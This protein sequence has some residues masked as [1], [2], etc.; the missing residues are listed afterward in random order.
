MKRPPIR[1]ARL[2]PLLLL[3]TSCSPFAPRGRV[4]VPGEGMPESFSM[5]SAEPPAADAPWWRS[6][7]FEELDELERRALRGN[8]T[9]REAW[10]RLKQ[11]EAQARKAGAPIYPQIDAVANASWTRYQEPPLPGPGADSAVEDYMLGLAGAYELDLWGRI[12]SGHRAV[13]LQA[14]ASREDLDTALM[15]VSARV[16]ELWLRV[17]GSR[18]EID[19]MKAQVETNRQILELVEM[20]FRKSAGS[21]LDVYRQR[22]AVERT[23]S[24]I[25]QI[26]AAERTFRNELAVMLGLPPESDLAI[27]TAELPDPG[28]LPPTGLPAD[29]LARRPDVRAAFARLESADWETAAA[30]ADRLPAIR[31]TGRGGYGTQEFE[32]IFDNWFLNLAGAVTGPIVDGGRRRAEVDRTLAQVD[33]R[34]ASYRKTVLTALREVED[35]LV[36]ENRQAEYVRRLEKQ[37]E[38][39]K[40]ALEEARRQYLKGLLDYLSVLAELQ[41]VQN[42]QRQILRARVERLVYRVAL[43]R[44]LGGTWMGVW[45]PRDGDAASSGPGTSRAVPEGKAPAEEDAER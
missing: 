12:R 17:I 26:E 23:A 42:L 7:G 30:R 18:M 25:P 32:S 21:A 34:L 31:L 22:E 8:L 35:A 39:A 43:Y 38:A 4:L 37:M 33:E 3:A 29:L 9:L 15:T 2:V 45:A 14:K 16:A 36:R 10:A 44:A 13:L 19:L 1:A 20:R 27:V 28:E 5:G 11:V 6:F 40:I 41:A 24:A